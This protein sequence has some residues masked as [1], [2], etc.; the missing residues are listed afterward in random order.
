MQACWLMASLYEVV[1][2][3]MAC[4]QQHGCR[5]LVKW[6]LRQGKVAVRFFRVSEM[7]TA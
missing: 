6:Q 5:G 1:R 2:T 3:G 7:Q 4:W